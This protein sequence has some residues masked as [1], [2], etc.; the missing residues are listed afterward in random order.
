MGVALRVLHFISGLGPGGAEHMLVRLVENTP[1]LNHHVLSLT[2]PGELSPAL[3][4]AGAVLLEGR[5]REG[6]WN[7]FLLQTAKAVRTVQPNV[8]Q[9]WM[10]HGNLA[11]LFAVR[12][13]SKQPLVW[14]IRQQVPIAQTA[15][16]HQQA[17]IRLQA[18]GSRFADAIIYNSSAAACGH[19]AIGFKPAKRRLIPNGFDTNIFRPDSEAR[20]S[21]RN[22]LGL[23]DDT[24]AIGLVARFDPW[25]NHAAFFSVCARLLESRDDLVF[26]LAGKDMT[27]NNPHVNSLVSRIPSRNLRLLGDRRDVPRIVCGLDIATNVSLGE[28]FPNA[29]GEAMSCAKF[30]VATPVGATP[31]LIENCG[32]IASGTDEAEIYLALLRAVDMG[33]DQRDAVGKAARV[34]IQN[35]FSIQAVAQQY[36]ELYRELV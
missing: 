27:A 5:K 6:L 8:I 9:G 14:N 31:T 11:S 18:R 15:K 36:A 1:E 30:C 7:T 21:V 20:R 34:R 29:V 28:G 33:H 17:A 23:S 24:L 32:L 22:E 13:R 19:E 10:Y 25:K 16:L 26:V 4:A 12:T 35:H 2:G 3:E